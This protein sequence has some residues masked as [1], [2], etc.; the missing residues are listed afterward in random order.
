MPS[1]KQVVLSTGNSEKEVD[2]PALRVGPIPKA[3][4]DIQASLDNCELVNDLLS[5]KIPSS[6]E[7]LPSSGKPTSFGAVF[8]LK[9]PVL[10]AKLPGSGQDV[11]L[12]KYNK[13][14]PKQH[15]L[16]WSNTVSILSKYRDGRV[17]P[18]MYG[19]CKDPGDGFHYIVVEWIDLHPTELPKPTNFEQC[20][21]RMEK[22]VK[23]LVTLDEEMHL[24][25]M[26]V[27]RGQWMS[28]PDKE[29]FVLQ[30]VDDIVPSPWTP[31][32]EAG[33][34]YH[35]Q[36]AGAQNIIQGTLPPGT[37]IGH[38]KKIWDEE[39]FP[40]GYTI[41]YTMILLGQ[42]IRSDMGFHWERDCRAGMPKEF[43]TCFDRVLGWAAT[44]K[45]DWP[46]PKQVLWA[47]NECRTH[48]SFDK[49]DPM[50]IRPTAP[51][52]DQPAKNGKPSS[53]T[54]ISCIRASDKVKKTDSAY[55][56]SISWCESTESGIV[57]KAANQ[58][59]SPSSSCCRGKAQQPCYYLVPEKLC[60]TLPPL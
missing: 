56:E 4:S 14:L 23:M 2:D 35:D 37:S 36:V 41:R 21:D 39:F 29:S 38:V 51:W 8:W 40:N 9:S 46:A 34:L 16:K 24:T 6:T 53:T 33:D 3:T 59:S 48:G 54:H 26:D 18:K 19:Y 11:V 22:L 31:T 58:S 17:F 32:N 20:F 1:T 30:D 10:R 42:I 47:V 25:F 5:G 7:G 45:S 52:R 49:T 27:K 55:T 57:R 15:T 60:P 28:R 44:P 12:L 43:I 50:A 13:Y